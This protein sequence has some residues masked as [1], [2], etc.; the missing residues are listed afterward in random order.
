M[1]VLLLNYQTLQ[2]QKTQAFLCI[3]ILVLFYFSLN[4]ASK[5]LNQS[6]ATVLKVFKFELLNPTTKK[7]L[8]DRWIDKKRE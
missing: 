8:T 1:E 3:L 6:P 5:I 7:L 4:V 2:A